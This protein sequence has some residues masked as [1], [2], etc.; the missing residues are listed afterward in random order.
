M[1]KEMAPVG[2][3]F[4]FVFFNSLLSGALHRFFLRFVFFCSFFRVFM[5]GVLCLS[6]FQKLDILFDLCLNPSR[7]KFGSQAKKGG[8]I[9]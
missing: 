9:I 6:L 5:W 8:Y 7:Y 3:L 2:R 4:F 1:S